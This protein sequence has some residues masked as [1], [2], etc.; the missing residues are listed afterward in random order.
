MAYIEWSA[1]YSVGIKSIDDQHKKLFAIINSLHEAMKAGKS[2]DVLGKIIKELSDYAVFHFSNEEN[3]MHN[4]LYTGYGSHKAEHDKFIVKVVE[5][6]KKFS[7]SSTV[8]AID[9]L[10]FLKDWLFKHVNGTDK[11]YSP[12]LISKGIK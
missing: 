1:E 5:Y 10:Q 11:K 6:E 9:M 7:A 8:I 3:L 2:K 12:F 4:L